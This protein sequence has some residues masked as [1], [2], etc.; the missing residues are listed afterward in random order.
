[1]V[2]GYEVAQAACQYEAVE[3]FV[4]AEVF[5]QTVKYR[6]LAG[7]NNTADGVNNTAGQQPEESAAVK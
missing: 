2:H 6:E 3:N 5:V 4:G 7:I 1:M